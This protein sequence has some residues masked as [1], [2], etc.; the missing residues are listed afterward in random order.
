[1]DRSGV[2]AH[3]SDVENGIDCPLVYDMP[4]RKQRPI[5]VCVVRISPRNDVRPTQLGS[6]GL[7][8]VAACNYSPHAIRWMSSALGKGRALRDV[9]LLL[10]RC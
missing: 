2:L 10:S 8:T 6:L 9:L 4:R 7:R 3:F 1:M 5:H